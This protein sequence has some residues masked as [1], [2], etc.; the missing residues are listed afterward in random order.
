MLESLR[1]ERR[2]V[3]FDHFIVYIK[4]KIF[5][6]DENSFISHFVLII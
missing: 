1:N 4:I 6:H 3:I 5:N 2:E